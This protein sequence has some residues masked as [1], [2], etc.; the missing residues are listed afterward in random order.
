MAI[1]KFFYSIRE[2]HYHTDDRCGPGNEIPEHNRRYD[3]PGINRRTLCKKCADLWNEQQNNQA[4]SDQLA[5][6]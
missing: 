3:Q 2:E 1:T 6:L 4:F 5:G